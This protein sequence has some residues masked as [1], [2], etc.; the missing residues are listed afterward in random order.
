MRYLFY[1]SCVFHKSGIAV[2]S[3]EAE[4]LYKEGNEVVLLYCGGVINVCSGN[5][6]S[7]K[8][9]CKTCKLWTKLDL[10]KLSKGI[11]VVSLTNYDRTT[12]NYEWKYDSVKELRKLQ[13]RNTHI[14]LATLS[15][16]IDFTRNL[17]PLIDSKSKVYFDN[18]LSQGAK[19]VDCIDCAINEIKPDAFCL[20]N[21]RLIETR[22]IL[23]YVIGHKIETRV[24]EV[25]PDV[26]TNQPYKVLYKNCMPHDTKYNQFLYEETWNKSTLSEN[27]KIE[28]ADSFY[29]NRR[30][31]KAA[32]DKIYTASQEE[33]ILPAGFDKN[34]R[35]IAIFNSSEDEMAAIGGEY[36]ELPLFKSQLI[37]IKHIL[38][39]NKNNRNIHFYLRIHPNLKTIKYKYH[40]ELYKFSDEFSNVTVIGADEKVDTYCLMDNVEKVIVF[41]STMGIES[42]YW[43]KPVI[44]LAAAMYYYTDI[45]YIPKTT[46]E[47]Q[48]LIE[49][50][51][52]PKFNDFVY[53]Y[54][55]KIMAAK[56]ASIEPKMFNYFDWTPFKINLFG[57]EAR[58]VN[59][60]TL[61]GSK[62]LALSFF[63]IMRVLFEKT[64]RNKFLLPRKEA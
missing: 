46:E 44:L 23:D 60:Q 30:H 33:G 1:S 10:S 37:G 21:G 14:G 38:E 59:Y 24:M 7:N 45:C 2:L 64:H 27:K 8:G 51:L 62:K 11:K 20:F 56:E 63:S 19:L 28:I 55:F 57:R 4:R 12:H 15:S 36:D 42:V 26:E 40:T 32:G 31:H 48:Q 47:L 58:G 50:K 49:A 5:S 25:V 16:Y 54:G 39:S 61:F 35:N 9:L 52:E 53:K 17:N 34:K 43:K 13:Y 6:C 18:A 41:G 29:Q 22:G 3:D